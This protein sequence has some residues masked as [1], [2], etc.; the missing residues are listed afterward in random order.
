MS[1]QL[2]QEVQ[3]YEQKLQYQK[4]LKKEINALKPIVF[5][6]LQSLPRNSLQ[7]ND[8]KLRIAEINTRSTINET[9]AWNMFFFTSLGLGL[10]R[11]M[12]YCLKV[13]CKMLR[14]HL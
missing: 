4:E 7:M 12:A 9:Q 2:P 8:G 3:L 11:V 13:V 10:I 14:T 1:F 5:R 6:F